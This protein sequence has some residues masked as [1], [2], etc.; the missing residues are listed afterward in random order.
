[1]WFCFGSTASTCLLRNK[2]VLKC[3]YDILL[4][5]DIRNKCILN[6]INH[7]YTYSTINK[8]AGR[9]FSWLERPQRPFPVA[10]LKGSRGMHPPVVQI[11]SI[12][13]SFWPNLAKSYV[14]TPGSWRPL[15]GEILDPQLVLAKLRQ[16]N[17][18]TGV[19]QS[20][21]SHTVC[22]PQCMLAYTPWEGTP[23][24]QVQS[25]LAGTPPGRVQS[26]LA[27]T[28][29]QAGTPS[30]QVHNSPSGRYT[31]PPR[32][33]TPPEQVQSH[34]VG[35]HPQVGTPSRQV[36]SQQ[37]HPLAGTQLPLRQVHKPTWAGTLPGRY[38]PHPR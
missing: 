26:H 31:N 34:L 27:G 16:G 20:F 1:M 19:C 17:I 21:C 18:F 37:V 6:H 14:G 33:G 23:P 5:F 24:G 29:S 11:L 4:R 32:A 35:T 13:C 7:L 28:H 15:L 8:V 22:L 9:V 25:H 3:I 36:P 2:C 38:T 10:D 30:R 12:S